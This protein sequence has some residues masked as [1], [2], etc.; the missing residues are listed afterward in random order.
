MQEP[1][2]S[3]LFPTLTFYCIETFHYYFLFFNLLLINP[4]KTISFPQSSQLVVISIE[5]EAQS[6][7]ANPLRYSSGIYGFSFTNFS[8]DIFS[9]MQIKHN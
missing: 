8:K 7:Y 1:L 2:L 9:V 3:Q 6:S 5:I 4:Q